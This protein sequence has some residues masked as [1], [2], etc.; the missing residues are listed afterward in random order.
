[1]KS[2][3]QESHN[4]CS[5]S[6]FQA[7]IWVPRQSFFDVRSLQFRAAFSRKQ[8]QVSGSEGTEGSSAWLCSSLGKAVLE[9]RGVPGSGAPSWL[10]RDKGACFWGHTEHWKHQPSRSGPHCTEPLQTQQYKCTIIQFAPRRHAGKLS[11]R[12]I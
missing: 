11:H 6:V 3:A 5:W 8:C 10:H 1:M 12:E 4:Q 9:T 7:F 2:K